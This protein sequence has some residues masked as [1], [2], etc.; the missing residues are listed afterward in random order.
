MIVQC[1]SAQ[2]LNSEDKIQKAIK[3]DIGF[4]KEICKILV[5]T[6]SQKSYWINALNG[7]FILDLDCNKLNYVLDTGKTLTKEEIKTIENLIDSINNFI[8]AENNQIQRKDKLDPFILAEAI[9]QTIY[10]NTGKDATKSLYNVVELFLFKFLSD[11][12][13]L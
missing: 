10:V 3:Q 9:W 7:Q 13:V 2:E 1:K 11:I 6:D 8:T 4:T 5:V 12:D